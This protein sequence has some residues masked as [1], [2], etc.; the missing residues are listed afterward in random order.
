MSGR[1]IQLIT[2]DSVWLQRCYVCLGVRVVIGPEGTTLE[3]AVPQQILQGTVG[4][5]PGFSAG[6]LRSDD[7]SLNA[8]CPGKSERCPHSP[9]KIT[10][11]SRR[12]ED[13][14]H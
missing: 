4:T 12:E 5:I 14:C 9:K 6:G 2:Q 7:A 10:R 8:T 3:L 11:W 1:P 13:V